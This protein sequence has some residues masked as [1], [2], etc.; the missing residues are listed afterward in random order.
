MS[1]YII[2]NLYLSDKKDQVLAYG[3]MRGETVLI[4]EGVKFI[5]KDCFVK[6]GI[7]EVIFPTSLECVGENAFYGCDKIKNIYIPNEVELRT[8]SFGKTTDLNKVDIN[9]KAIPVNCF[10]FSG[11]KSFRGMEI[12]LRGTK[13]IEPLA[14]ARS[15]LSWTNF[16]GTLTEIKEK[17]FLD[18]NFNRNV[19][20]L[21]KNLKILGAEAFKGTNI[22]DI[23]VSDNIEFIDFQ[24]TNIKIHLSQKA[25][26]KINNLY[27]TQ[28]FIDKEHLIIED[29]IDELLEKMTFKE[30]NKKY[31]EKEKSITDAREDV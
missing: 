18:A 30:L 8:S 21:P 22:S 16:P 26:N 9:C 13:I 5:A 7:T 6:S 23:Y 15:F 24:D 4:P 29:S 19:I 17:A 28:L 2:N 12:T 25:Y 27:P 20:V 11:A 10:L 14:F 31:L 1:T 3:G